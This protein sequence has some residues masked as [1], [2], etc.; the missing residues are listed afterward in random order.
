MSDFNDGCLC[1][2]AIIF[3]I[4]GLVCHII[5]LVAYLMGAHP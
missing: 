3:A 1:G 5:C 2:A 4:I